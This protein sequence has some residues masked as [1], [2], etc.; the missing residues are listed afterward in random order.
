MELNYIEIIGYIGSVLVAISLMMKNIFYLRRINFLG[1]ATF[2]SYGLMVGAIPVFVLNGFIALVDIYYIL[3]EKKQKEYFTLLSIEQSNNSLL[4]KFISFYMD[5]IKKFFPNFDKS[6]IEEDKSFFIL[7]NL[8]P[9]G[10][11]AYKELND[12][13]ILIELDYAIPDY[14]DLKNARF[15]YFA[16]SNH[17]SKK[18]YEILHAESNVDEHK[19]Y[20]KKIGFKE[21]PPNSGKYKKVLNG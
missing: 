2:A 18:G 13:E 21:I 20:L 5:D 12:K 8:I 14:R 15:V 1:A 6:K 3:D 10:L 9:V 11:F 7:R 4:K 19:K 17:F 16:Q